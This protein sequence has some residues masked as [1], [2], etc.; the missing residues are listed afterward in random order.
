M[1]AHEAE[2]RGRLQAALGPDFELR[3]LIGRGGFGAVYSAWD[4]ALEREV[5]VKALRHD[6]FPTPVVLER[7]KREAKALGRLR[8]AHI[9]PV[10]EVGEG[11]G[12]AF[13][14]TPLIKG[15]TLAGF[16]QRG[17]RVASAEALRLT[18]EVA[19]ALDAAHR[20]G[21]VHRDVKPENIL[22]EGPDRHAV[23]ADFGIAK[24]AAAESELTGAGVAIGSPQYMSPE[25][26][27]AE[28]EIDG[29]SDI[30]SL[31]AVAYEMLAGRRPYEANSLQRLL[32]LQFTTEPAPLAAPGT[33][34]ETADVVMK[35]L[36]RDRASRWQT[37]GEFAAALSTSLA[38]TTPVETESWLAKRGLLLVV[39][40]IVGVY[41]TIAS[42]VL[43][44][45]GGQAVRTAVN[46]LTVPVRAVLMFALLLFFV[47][48]IG[49]ML[50]ARPS[51][52]DGTWRPA[53]RAGF[54]QPRWWQAWYP[55]WLRSADSAWDRMP[56]GVKLLRTLLWLD[57]AVI[58][59]AIPLVFGVPQ[60]SSTAASGGIALPLP[61]RLFIG[62]GILLRGPWLAGI[63][64]A[65]AGI[66]ALAITKRVRPDEVVRLLLTWSARDWDSPAGRKLQR[67]DV[68]TVRAR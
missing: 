42:F 49:T 51:R 29:R 33:S 10:Y 11:D 17:E 24:A 37:A 31:G 56:F 13:M 18:I 64:L 61:V 27:S 54:G 6:M 52:T 59:L 48:L 45:G 22:I 60:L 9:L 65:A 38:R 15:E 46:M 55:R 36:A 58:P 28:K 23:L 16:L 43:L 66:V 20:A 57:V 26:A 40:D 4:K 47:E 3:E 67:A 21:I 35:A 34:T 63:A 50:R 44:S 1:D 62:A 25:Q 32:V 2:Y 14:V 7:F 19:R 39:I 5:A 30:Y 53:W 41:M 8:H 12:I 68:A